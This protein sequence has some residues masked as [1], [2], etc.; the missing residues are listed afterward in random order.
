MCV[1]AAAASAIWPI[2]RVSRV[3]ELARAC[4]IAQPPR[5]YKHLPLP[6]NDLSVWQIKMSSV[7]VNM[8]LAR[9]RSMVCAVLC[10]CALRQDAPESIN[11][12]AH[13]YMSRVSTY[14]IYSHHICYKTL[15]VFALA[16]SI[17]KCVAGNKRFC[18]G[19]ANTYSLTPRTLR[20]QN[21]S[22][23]AFMMDSP[24][25]ECYIYDSQVYLCIYLLFSWIMSCE[26]VW[27]GANI[28]HKCLFDCEKR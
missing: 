13:K 22:L 24:L 1:C 28:G 5:A 16:R 20:A 2:A 12:C 15:R 8:S 11:A 26:C 14:Y 18:R 27:S 6:S 10:G 23:H 9:A 4:C 3:M 25:V 19:C 21:T 7:V 17:Y